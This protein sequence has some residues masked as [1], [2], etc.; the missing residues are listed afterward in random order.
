MNQQA[1]LDLNLTHA[2]DE[3]SILRVDSFTPNAIGGRNSVRIESKKSYD[4]GLF[5]FDII[6]TPYGCG[7]WP[8]LWLVDGYNWPMNGEIDILE[9]TNEA[10][11]GNAVT[12][13]TTEG[14]KMNVKRKETGS[15]IFKDCGNNTHS[16]AGCSVQG[17]PSTYGQAFNQ[18]GGGVSGSFP[19]YQV[20]TV[21]S[22]V[23]KHLGLRT[24]ASQRGHSGMVL[25]TRLNSS[26]CQ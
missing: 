2:T 1:A 9:A 14:C 17:G 3:S 23:T 25:P 7:T 26:R 8:A 4:H 6:H 11:N 13:H 15:P 10:S 5:V 20:S 18:G 21:V 24:R 12:L 19:F 22:N 16:N